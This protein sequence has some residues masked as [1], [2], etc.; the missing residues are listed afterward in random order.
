MFQAIKYNA[1]DLKIEGL[2]LCISEMFQYIND[3]VDVD[4]I[5]N[6]KSYKFYSILSKLIVQVSTKSKLIHFSLQ[7]ITC[8]L[9]L[10][11]INYNKKTY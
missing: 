3:I 11:T 4:D 6:K 2:L 8:L 1:L 9:N 7:S 5:F 10:A